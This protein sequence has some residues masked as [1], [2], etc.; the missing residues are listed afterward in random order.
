MIFFGFFR[1]LRKL[2]GNWR[3]KYSPQILIFAKYNRC[4]VALAPH[5]LHTLDHRVGVGTFERSYPCPKKQKKIISRF[6]ARAQYRC[7]NDIV[8]H[9]IGPKSLD[10]DPNYLKI[11][12][13]EFLKIF[14]VPVFRVFDEFFD[15]FSFKRQIKTQKI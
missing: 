9:R 3:R 13:L 11:I 14:R 10:R 1:N 2:W 7:K 6:H 5:I 15:F 12:F 4:R 8:L